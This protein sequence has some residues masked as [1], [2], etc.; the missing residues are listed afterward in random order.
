ML[1]CYEMSTFKV[2]AGL[3]R[4]LHRVRN[5]IRCEKLFVA[6]VEVIRKEGHN[7]TEMLTPA[8][9]TA[10]GVMGSSDS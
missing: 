4:F 8:N 5:S 9:R 7:R 10:Q 3:K 2:R 6:L 1:N